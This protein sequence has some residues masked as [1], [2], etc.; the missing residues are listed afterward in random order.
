MTGDTLLTV[1]DLHASYDVS[2]VLHGVSLDVEEGGVTGLVGRNGAGKT[3][4]LRSILGHTTITN[5]T[6]VFAGTEITDHNPV[7]TVTD[8]I[9]F[10]PEG[11]RVFAD[12]TV[13]ENL[14]VG[15][16][17][18]TD[19]SS[20]WDSQEVFDLFDNLAESRDRHAS[21][22]SGGEQQMLAIGRVLVQGVDLLL[23]DEPT[24]GL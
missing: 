7:E 20:A 13:E 10:V 5:G 3:T 21:S 24:E 8:G 11:R 19:E 4:T 12:L 17:G 6:V 23:L 22:L 14:L 2:K 9:G 15:E 18:R 1:E 16:T